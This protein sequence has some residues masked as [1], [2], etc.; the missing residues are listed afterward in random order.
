[1]GNLIIGII[2]LLYGLFTLYLR[3]FKESKGLGK[4]ENMKMMLGDKLGT[5][6]H[7]FSYT[8]LP[9][10]IGLYFIVRYYYPELEI[11]QK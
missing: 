9:I 2:G 1:M 4:L 8:I 3:I 5:I 7:V 6:L 11:F 10:C